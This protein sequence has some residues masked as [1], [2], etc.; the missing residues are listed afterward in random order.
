MMKMMYSLSTGRPPTASCGARRY[1][2]A[3]HLLHFLG[4]LLL[5]GHQLALELVG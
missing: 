2:G 1:S 5:R 3:E 4:Q